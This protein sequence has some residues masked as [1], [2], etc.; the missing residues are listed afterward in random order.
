M[1]SKRMGRITWPLHGKFLSDL[2]F[3]RGK[4]RELIPFEAVTDVP[5]ISFSEELIAAY[6]DAKVIL[7]V[8]DNEDVWYESMINTIWTGHVLFSFPK[9][10]LQSLFQKIAPRPMIWRTLQYCY[11]YTIKE[12]FPTR[13]K[14]NYLEHNAKIKSL[15]PKERFLLFNAKQ[16][17]G[18]LC[19]FLGVPVPD[20]PFPWVN[21]TKAWK[22]QVT[23]TKKKAAMN[24]AKILAGLG[25]VVV[26]VHLGRT[27]WGQ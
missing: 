7:T 18:P 22:A 15:V 4:P 14:Q 26:G 16:G 12:D 3:C 5:V 6:P 21:D 10:L 9:S 2:L 17:W 1:G 20:K 8:R 24:V 23:K 13:G 11:K 19:E 27:G 25:V